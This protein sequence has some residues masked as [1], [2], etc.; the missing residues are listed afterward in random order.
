MTG[1]HSAPGSGGWSTVARA[2]QEEEDVFRLLRGF[3]TRPPTGLAA[4]EA[5][6]PRVRASTLRP[7]AGLSRSH[8]THSPPRIAWC[9]R[10]VLSL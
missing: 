3:D 8:S 9:I 10:P 7:L 4:A 2:R 1:K 6:R 5:P